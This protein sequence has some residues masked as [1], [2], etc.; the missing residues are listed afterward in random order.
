MLLIGSLVCSVIFFILQNFIELVSEDDDAFR[1]WWI[2]TLYWEFIYFIVITYIAYIWLPSQN[3]LRYAYEDIEVKFNKKHREQD[4]EISL[5]ES[6]MKK[7]KKEIVESSSESTSKKKS[8]T[9]DDVKIDQS[10]LAK[11]EEKSEIKLES[12]K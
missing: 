6:Q 7:K 2:F 3:N 10:E 12:S 11:N 1:V 4:G 8:D 5:E 9:D